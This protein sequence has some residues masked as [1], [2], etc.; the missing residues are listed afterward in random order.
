[1]KSLKCGVRAFTLVELLVV[2]GIIA[3]LLGI[4]LPVLSKARMAAQEV[5]CASNMRQMGIGLM[6][7]I[8]ENKGDFP[9]DAVHASPGQPQRSWIYTL[10]PMLGDVDAIRICPADEQGDLR[11]QSD[12]TSYILNWYVAVPEVDM[13][14]RPVYDYTNLSRIRR[15]SETV[16]AFESSDANGAG[17]TA[18]HTHSNVWFSWPTAEARWDSLRAVDGMQPDRHA[19]RRVPDNT[20]G[21]SNFL[22]VDG[23]VNG[24]DAGWVR[25]K[26]DA[27]ENFAIPP[28]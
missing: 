25:R 24:I 26:I 12:G 7:Y 9:E 15:P 5:S 2:I 11:R 13:F 20:K 1:M 22:Y 3:L 27:N 18:D 19:T 6:M 16:S 28:G 8:N 14:G 21:R 17:V 10:S 4:L 23:H